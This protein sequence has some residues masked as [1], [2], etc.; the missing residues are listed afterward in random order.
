[1]DANQNLPLD[2]NQTFSGNILLFYSFDVGDDIDLSSI[3]NK[4]ILETFE[5]PL[6]SYFKNYRVPYSFKYSSDCCASIDEGRGIISGSGCVL[7]K[8]Y[9]FGAL[10]FC[11]QIPFSENF[12]DLKGKLIELKREYDVK[13]EIDARNVF[14]KI[15][16]FTK[17]SRF[18][19]LKSDYIAVQV[20]PIPERIGSIDFKDL[21]GARIASLLRLETK[22]LSDYQIDQILSSTTG[23]YGQD[24]IIIDSKGAFIYDNEYFEPLEFFESANVQMLEL[25]YYDRL[26]DEKLTYFYGQQTHKVP[27]R[28]YLPLVG[29][30]FDSPISRL[31]NLRVDISVITEQLE[32]SV[33]MTGDAYYLNFYSMLVEK[34]YLKEW[35]DSINR[36][37][38]I[39]QDLNAVYQDRLDTIHEEV[40]TIVVIILIAFEAII[41]FIR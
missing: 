17:K 2:V 19:N 10:S 29:E 18:F 31:A 32:N 5:V 11:Y 16:V 13:S 28:V 7:S 33:K 4:N 36:K 37:L 12:D 39:I 23:Y 15:N 22:T 34:L 25:Q 6:S 14:N 24:L 21:Y 27:L 9:H 3:K 41:P 1:M 8:A 38:K 26:I 35:R 20:N 40:L 30:R